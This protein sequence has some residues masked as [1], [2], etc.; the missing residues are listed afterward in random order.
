MLDKAAKFATSFALFAGTKDFRGGGEE[1]A[2]DM[3]GEDILIEGEGYGG[4]LEEEEG[5]VYAY[6]C[7]YD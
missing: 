1:I 4:G 2:P 3:N 5:V 6:R 7:W